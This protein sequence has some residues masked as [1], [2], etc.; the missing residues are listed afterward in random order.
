MQRSLLIKIAQPAARELGFDD[1]KQ[2]IHTAT[3]SIVVH[4]A[5][6]VRNRIARVIDLERVKLIAKIPASRSELSGK[7]GNMPGNLDP[8]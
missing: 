3:E 6:H 2:R 7:N 5:T 8:I 1:V 4:S